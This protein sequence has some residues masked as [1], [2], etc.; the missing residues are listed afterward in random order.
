MTAEEEP[1]G[2][3]PDDW[4]QV[5]GQAAS[6]ERLA[7]I[8]CFVADRRAADRGVLPEASL[9]FAALH[10]TPFESVRAV[11][12][13]QDPYPNPSHA[14]GLAFS[15]PRDLPP[16][17]PRSL[18]NI[19]TAL[20]ADRDVALPDHGS[21]EAWTHHGVLLLNTALTVQQD[22]P[23]SHAEARWWVLT[24]AI[25]SA[26]A[27]KGEPVAFLLWGR[28]AQSKARLLDE[29][30]HIVVCSS[31]P[32]PLSASGFLGTRPFGRADDALVRLGAEP[33]DWSLNG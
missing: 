31:H 26:V 3:I 27:A 21:L 1:I 30:R 4:V 32:S 29:I 23:R 8:S 13:G 22:P 15:V 12:L 20:R 19:R 9:V 2:S 10:A 6:P 28:H 24:D 7:G 25:I 16:P 33:I 5:L 17:L 11:I 14:M 18:Q